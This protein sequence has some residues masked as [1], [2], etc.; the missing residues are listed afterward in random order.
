MLSYYPDSTTPRGAIRFPERYKQMI[1]FSGL[2]FG[3]CSPMD[4]D[5][6]LEFGGNEF[7]FGEF[8]HFNARISRGQKRALTTLTMLA[9]Q[10]GAA[11]LA[12]IARHNSGATDVVSGADCVVSEIL[13]PMNKFGWYCPGENRR[14]RELIDSWRIWHKAQR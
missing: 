7:V 4:I 6:Y 10:R 2:Q 13:C 5:C 12:F 1:D 3:K 9:H 11:V 8:K 14:V